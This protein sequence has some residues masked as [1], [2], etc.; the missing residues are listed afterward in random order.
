MNK[1]QEFLQWLDERYTI[2]PSDEYGDFLPSTIDANSLYVKFVTEKNSNVFSKDIQ[3]FMDQKIV[4]HF[5]NAEE[6]QIC[7]KKMEDMGYI[8]GN[9][10]NFPTDSRGYDYDFPY[11]YVQTIMHPSNKRILN[12][13]YKVENAESFGMVIK[14]AKDLDFMIQIQKDIENESHTIPEQEDSLERL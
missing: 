2:I 4:I 1:L 8:I 7:R 3:D 6:Y 10:R 5:D 14:E 13:S 12:N 9:P 11:C